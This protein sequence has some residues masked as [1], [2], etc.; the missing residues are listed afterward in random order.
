MEHYVITQ[1]FVPARL[2]DPLG[3]VPNEGRIGAQVEGEGIGGSDSG[4]ARVPVSQPPLL[5]QLTPIHW[6]ILKLF[7]P[8]RK[9]MLFLDTFYE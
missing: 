9:K 6:D 4:E 2:T 1:R 5:P 7:T 8:K 3:P